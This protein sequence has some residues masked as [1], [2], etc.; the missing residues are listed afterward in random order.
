MLNKYYYLQIQPSNN[1]E[2][3]KDAYK[4]IIKL[5]HPDKNKDTNEEFIN[6]IESYK[7]IVNNIEEYYNYVIEN[8][9]YYDLNIILNIDIQLNDLINGINKKVMI[10]KITYYYDKLELKNKIVEEEI[11]ININ[12]NINYNQKYIIKNRG[13]IFKQIIKEING[14]III[15]FNLEK[16]KD[17]MIFNNNLLTK[18][19]I[20]LY[21]SLFG[22]NMNKKYIDG[23][24]LNISNIDKIIQPYKIYKIKNYGIYDKNNIRGDLYI[25][26]KVIFPNKLDDE[27][28]QIFLE[29]LGYK[30]NNIKGGKNYLSLDDDDIELNYIYDVIYNK[31]ETTTLIY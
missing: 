31:K 7:Y 17:Y 5:Y 16:N 3:I 22:F 30:N 19:E 21:Q 12:N 1:I 23:K 4:K 25:Q 28:K 15:F 10:N 24:L 9:E 8:E 27:K 26:F 20:T 2:Y 14:N 29:I 18:I 6:V 11:I 13:N